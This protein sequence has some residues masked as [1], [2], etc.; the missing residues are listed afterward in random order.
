MGERKTNYEITTT[1]RYKKFTLKYQQEDDGTKVVDIEAV[2]NREIEVRQ[3]KHNLKI[4]LFWPKLLNS[5]E[6]I[7][8]A[9]EFLAQRQQMGYL[10]RGYLKL[11][12]SFGEQKLKA[13]FEVNGN[14]DNEGHH[15]RANLQ[16]VP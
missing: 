12:Y 9:G 15:V 8:F 2:A 5:Q 1:N 7:Q 16:V 4:R 10:K 13:K 3:I 11:Q 6:K 14:E